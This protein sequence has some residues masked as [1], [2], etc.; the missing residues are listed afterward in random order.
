[1]STENRNYFIFTNK[2]SKKQRETEKR[3]EKELMV[4]EKELNIS[5]EN[6][7]RYQSLKQDIEDIKRIKTEGIM[8][9]SKTKWLE[10]GEKN[11]KYFF[12]FEKRNYNI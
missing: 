3:L 10:Y 11:S 8:L 1:M 4:L 5:N 6:Y 7:P 9:R 12:N 2:K